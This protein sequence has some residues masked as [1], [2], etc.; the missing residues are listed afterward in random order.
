M[1]QCL[2]LNLV[3]IDLKFRYHFSGNQKRCW[4]VQPPCFF[5]HHFQ[6]MELMYVIQSD[7]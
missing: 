5:D 4:R 3:A 6:V 7:H 2:G 1:K